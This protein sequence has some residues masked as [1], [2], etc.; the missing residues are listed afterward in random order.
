[1]LAKSCCK[2]EDTKNTV[3]NGCKK[4]T[5]CFGVNPCQVN[6]GNKSGNNRNRTIIHNVHKT[7]CK[8][9]GKNQQPTLF[10]QRSIPF[11]QK[12]SENNLLQIR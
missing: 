11:K 9:T 8:T 6:A 3:Q 1:M 10:E 7:E 5:S 12:S 4:H 2:H